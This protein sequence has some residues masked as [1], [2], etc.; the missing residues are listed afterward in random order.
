MGTVETLRRAEEASWS[1]IE[2]RPAQ[3][4]QGYLL[5]LRTGCQWRL[6][7]RDYPP[8]TQV[9]GYWRRW[10][11]NGL[12]SRINAGL[13]EAARVKAGKQ[14]C[15]TVGIIDSRTVKTAQKG[16]SAALTAAS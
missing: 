15:P 9:A 12:W 10:T 7:P 8:W 4:H 1:K 3:C 11:A 5:R 14:P 2:S 16:G 6:L 13:R